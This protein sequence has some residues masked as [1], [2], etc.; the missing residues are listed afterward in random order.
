MCY[1]AVMLILCAQFAQP[2]ETPNV[3]VVLGPAAA[4]L[5]RY[6]ADG[7]LV[8][9]SAIALGVA[10]A[11]AAEDDGL[12]AFYPCDDGSGAV[13]HDQS[14]MGNDGQIVGGASWA[15]GA[16]GTALRLDGQDDYVDCGAALSALMKQAGSVVF[17][18]QPIA[19]CQGGLVAWTIGGRPPDQRLAVSLNTHRRNRGRGALV[20]EELGVYMS[21]GQGHYEAHQSNF[22]KAYFPPP[23]RW[24]HF[25][26]TWDGRS[27]NVYRD[28][29]WTYS[30]FQALV[31]E[32]DDIALWIGRC[33]GV[34]GPSDYFKG[35]IDNVRLYSRA[36]SSRFSRT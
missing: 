12:V 34:G 33:I 5:E 3:A 32:I 6:A 36:T 26:V 15:S 2:G 13:L 18:F 35:L 21:D 31:P 20:H 11:S 24:L 28:G 23:D 27:V 10:G 25:A 22:H 1:L 19:R 9:L 29:V 7:L 14:G 17:W 30:R 16:W 8:Y 4:P